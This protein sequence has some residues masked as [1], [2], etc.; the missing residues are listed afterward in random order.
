M[1]WFYKYALTTLK[2]KLCEICFCLQSKQLSKLKSAKRIDYVTKIETK[3]CSLF[4]LLLFA[5]QTIKQTEQNPFVKT[6][7]IITRLLQELL[8]FCN[9]MSRIKKFLFRLYKIRII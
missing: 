7:F 8:T 3:L 6:N 2:Q 1:Y 9:V 5:K 4:L